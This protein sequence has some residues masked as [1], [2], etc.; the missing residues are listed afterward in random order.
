MFNWNLSC[1]N[2]KPICPV[3]ILQSN[4]KQIHCV[5][6]MIVPQI[7][8]QAYPSI[9]G[10]VICSF[11]YPQFCRYWGCPLEQF[12]KWRRLKIAVSLVGQQNCCIFR[13]VFSPWSCLQPL[14]GHVRLFPFLQCCPRIHG[15]AFWDDIGERRSLPVPQNTSRT[16]LEV[17][18]GGILEALWGM[19]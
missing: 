14:P 19:D 3:P 11:R 13:D 7:F 17:A 8:V 9:C 2:F 5:F 4:R 12:R 1:C 10:F 6:H 18:S 15:D 16:W